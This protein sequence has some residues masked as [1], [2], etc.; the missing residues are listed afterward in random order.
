MANE[1][2]DDVQVLEVQV[3]Q[4]QVDTPLIAQ[5]FAGLDAPVVVLGPAPKYAGQPE[6]G[7]VR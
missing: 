3:P 2:Q 1:K 6:P 7:D 4:V 5:L